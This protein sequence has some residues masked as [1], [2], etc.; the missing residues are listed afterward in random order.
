MRATAL[1]AAVLAALAPVALPAPARGAASPWAVNGPSRLRLLS[2]YLAAPAGGEVRL[3]LELRTEPGWHVYWKN[4]G[5]A[6]YPP[7]VEWSGAGLAPGS[8]PELLW[9]A[10]RR[11]DLAG[12][13]VAFGYEGEVI[14]PVRARLAAGAG[15]A[16]RLV[17]DVDYLV[18][19]VDCIPF[20]SRLA[21]DQPVAAAAVPDPATAAA[22]DAWFG[23]LPEAV[24]AVP[25]AAADLR[26]DPAGPALE[27]ALRGV[28]A[29]PG[30]DLFLEPQ[31]LFD[32]AR[33]RVRAT[34]GGVI[35]RL[36]LARSQVDRPLPAA[37]PFAWTATGLQG[38]RGPLAL[39]GRSAVAL[40]P[41][42]PAAP[43]GRRS[44][45][46]DLAA[47]L[48][49]GLLLA[50]APAPLALFLSQAG[51]LRARAGRRVA[52]MA[53]AA[54]LACGAW[55]AAAAA[56]AGAFAGWG[57]PLG[58]PAWTAG[59]A[60]LALLVALDLWG[61]FGTPLAP[62]AAPARRAFAAGLA[63]PL[64]ALAW[65]LPEALRVDLAPRAPAAAW[66]AAT[67][68]ALGLAL[69]YA[70][71]AAYVAR[72]AHAAAGRASGERAAG[73]LPAREGLG[74]LA[75]AAA[76]WLLYRLAREVRPEGLA[77]S[78]LAL[79]G[80]AL[81]AWVRRPL[82]RGALRRALAALLLACALA[83]P[84]VAAGSGVAATMTEK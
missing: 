17:A 3:G 9:P 22:V 74:F 25:G 11:F 73:G 13:L 27:L 54:G 40:A 80:A 58:H 57:T 52:G 45:A 62:G 5:D 1:L 44:L 78:E 50:L 29:G 2:P 83:A 77:A 4:S 56:R 64:L 76:L 20:R 61:M 68:V 53:R 42:A 14:Y 35:F 65:P 31:D 82:R 43:A 55:G 46:R 66:L 39:A 84:L 30:A 69:P 33:P 12:G 59:L 60:A 21:L 72:T 49:A 16:A 67:A 75:A 48:A 71:Y 41:P 19:Q 79:L 38:T 47:A 28:A 81:L 15:T 6:G 18:C 37:A 36:P 70:A 51:A 24:S 8:R 7:K 32:T 63:A 34:A 23:R 26:Y 10:P